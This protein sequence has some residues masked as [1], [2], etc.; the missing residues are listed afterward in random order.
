MEVAVRFR[1][2]R[3]SVLS[4]R[5]R[6]RWDCRPSIC[7][8]R[9]IGLPNFSGLLR[10]YFQNKPPSG[11]LRAVGQPIACTVTEQL[12]DL[13]ARKLGIDP[14]ELRRRNYAAGQRA[15]AASP[16]IVLGEL[17]LER[18]HDALLELMGYDGLR[19][20]QAASCA[21]SG[22]YRGIGLAVFIE[23]TGVGPRSTARAGSGFRARGL[24]LR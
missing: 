22:I 16:G 24:P 14:A 23:Q 17:S 5:Q 7:R 18:C 10:G 19:R 2:R 20:E 11:V 12:F 15:C 4:A 13:A 3:L 9:P 21:T 8:R 6:R 1:L